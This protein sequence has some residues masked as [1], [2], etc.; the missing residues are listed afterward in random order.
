LTWDWWI[1]GLRQPFLKM[2]ATPPCSGGSCVY[3]WII[4]GRPQEYPATVC[5]P[6][7]VQQPHYW[8]HG[9]GRKITPFQWHQPTT[10][11]L[12]CNITAE[13]RRPPSAERTARRQFQTNGQS[14]SQT[15]ASDAMTSRLLRHGCHAMRRSVCNAGA[16]NTGQSLWVQI[17][18]E[19][20]Y[21]PCQYI[22]T[23]RKAIDCATTLPLTVFI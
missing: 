23:T 17:S 18:R 5:N 11:T 12:T 15:Q 16:S 21:T 3:K 1:S 13:T 22:D 14:V 2:A 20:S 8:A 4:I 10:P 19:R 9:T 6:P 7:W